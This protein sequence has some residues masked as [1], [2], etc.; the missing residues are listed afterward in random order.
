MIGR[1]KI[2]IKRKMEKRNNDQKMQHKES[3]REQ[4]RRTDKL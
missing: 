2:K 4:W 3:K 1:W